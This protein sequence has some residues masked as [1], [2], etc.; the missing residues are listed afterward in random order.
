MDPINLKPLNHI[1]LIVWLDFLSIIHDCIMPKCTKA[2]RVFPFEV[3][4]ELIV[5]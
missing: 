5:A 2:I 1:K 4:M 3:Y